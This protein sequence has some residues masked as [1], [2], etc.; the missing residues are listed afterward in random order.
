VVPRSTLVFGNQGPATE[1]N[2]SCSPSYSAFLG[3]TGSNNEA[4]PVTGC[5]LS[6]LLVDPTNGDF[7]PKKGGTRPCT[8]D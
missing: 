5:A 6:D 7:H 8:F 4:I 2:A 3:A 1:I